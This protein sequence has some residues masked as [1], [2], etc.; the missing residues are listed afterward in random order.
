MEGIYSISSRESINEI[1]QKF[2]EVFLGRLGKYRN[3]KFKLRLKPDVVP[4]FRK[5]RPIP[6]SLKKRTEEELDRLVRER[7]L[8]QIKESEWATLIVPVFKKNGH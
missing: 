7:I 3:K 8:F 2:P 6:Y 1:L 4:V 5:A